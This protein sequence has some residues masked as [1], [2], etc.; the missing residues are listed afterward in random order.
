MA[1]APPVQPPK[2]QASASGFW[3]LI[4]ERVNDAIKD[5]LQRLFG[6]PRPR[7]V[8]VNIP[9]VGG[10]G[11]QPVEGWLA[12]A[13]MPYA[14]MRIV[15]WSMQALAAGAITIDIRSSSIQASPATPISPV[16]MPGIA[17]V[18]SLN[19]YSVTSQDTSAWNSRDLTAGSVINV[20]VMSVDTAIRSCVLALQLLDLDGKVLQQ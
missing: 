19:G 1:A 20:Y 15:G 16:S 10:T 18:L 13:V 2:P 6:V 17:N 12:S 7:P 4:D 14:N 3:T 8:V 11:V 5:V 9:L